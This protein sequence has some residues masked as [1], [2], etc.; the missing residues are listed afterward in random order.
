MAWLQVMSTQLPVNRHVQII[1]LVLEL[2]GTKTT[3]QTN[4][5]ICL[6]H[7]IQPETMDLLSALSIMTLSEA[8]KV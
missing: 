1:K 7:G 6:D 8:V 3:H 4:S 5:V 2:T